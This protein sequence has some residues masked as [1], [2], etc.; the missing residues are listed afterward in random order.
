MNLVAASRAGLTLGASVVAAALFASLFLWMLGAD[1]LLALRALVRGSLGDARALE[2]TL[3]RF[4]PLALVGLAVTLAFRSG[5]WNI[6]GEGQLYLGALVATAIATRAL[7]DAPA[8]VLVP[9]LLAGGALGGA[10][11]GSIAALLKVSRGVSEVLST[12][13][14][15][16]I[17]AL[18]VAWAVHGPLQEVS[19]AYPQSDALP[20]AA[21]LALLPGL[22][23]MHLGLVLALA[24]LP[25]VWF[26]LFRTAVGLR[27]RAVGLA[28]DA[29]RYA[30]IDPARETLGVLAVSGS[31]A[32]LAGAIEVSGVTGRLFENL[33]A[34]YGFTAIAVALLARLQPLA[35]LPAALFFAAIATGSAAMQRS[36]GVPSV[37]V[38][39]IEGLVILLSVGV[40]LPGLRSR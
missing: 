1:P 11:W 27:L 24:M 3:L 9:A 39:V 2:T 19:A 16:F 31:L 12:L 32:G 33:S 23:R 10:A 38:R 34:G 29:A 30:G 21:R 18:L 13:L 8:I 14:L 6:G 25:L 40:A 22:R 36:A 15:N 35:V 37:T 28:P 4:C 5:V 20:A 7:P 17:A 26:V